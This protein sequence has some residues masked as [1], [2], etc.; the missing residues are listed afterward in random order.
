[1]KIIE[2]PMEIDNMHAAICINHCSIS[3]LGFTCIVKP[4][5]TCLGS[6]HLFRVRGDGQ[7]ASEMAPRFHQGFSEALRRRRRVGAKVWFSWDY[8][9]IHEW[10]TIAHLI[11][12]YL[13]IYRWFTSQTHLLSNPQTATH[14]PVINFNLSGGGNFPAMF[15]SNT[16]C[17]THEIFT[18]PIKQPWIIPMPP[19]FHACSTQK[20]SI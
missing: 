12:I 9:L 8:P 7:P 2:I 3:E 4:C 18:I 14:Y 5:E 6:L 15:Q 17:E 20:H 16:N 1:M 11:F 19:P 13:P 10:F